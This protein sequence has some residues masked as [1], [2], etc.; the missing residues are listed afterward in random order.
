MKLIV[1][2]SSLGGDIEIPASKSHTIRA[3]VIA[4]L[5]DGKSEIINPLPSNDAL[6]CVNACKLLGAEITTDDNWI[7]EGF[8]G[9]PVVPKDVIDV[10]NSGTTLRIIT[11]VAALGEGEIKIT[12]DEMTKK[13]PM[14]PLLDALNNLGAKARSLNN[15]GCC[16]IVVEGK[17]KGGK[18]EVEGI[19]SQFLSSLLISCPLAEGDSEI[20]PVNL[21]EKPYVGMTLNWLDKQRI[22]YVNNNMQSFSIPGNQSYHSFKQ[23]VPGDFSSATFPLCAG[24]ITDSEITLLGLDIN[25]TQGDKRVIDVLKQMGADIKVMDKGI[26]V[27]GTELEG[28]EIDLND[29]PDSLPALSVVGCY[30][31][32]TTVIKNVAQAR[33]KE[34]D[35]IK[36]IAAELGKMNAD[37]KEMKDGLI[38]KNSRLSGAKVNGYGDHR[39]VMALSLAGMIAHGKTEISTA[40]AVNITY[41]NYVDS[42]MNLGANFIKE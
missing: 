23:R 28:I 42:M 36:A 25:D 35:R 27:K 10:G 21:H 6:S 17:I 26:V 39:I 1:E 37:I 30:A 19:T 2:K 32:G 24:A 34:T 7:V 22:K 15:N 20:I 40:E 18:T 12:G 11:S 31:K 14:Q 9:Q 5:A 3:V 13:R 38:I 41:P 8:G 4:S 29:M 16:P 33:I